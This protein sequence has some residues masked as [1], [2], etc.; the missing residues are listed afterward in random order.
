MA[1]NELHPPIDQELAES[2]WP[3]LQ[4]MGLAAG[5][6]LR[7]ESIAEFREMTLAG[8][9]STVSDGLLLG[10]R[11]EME[12]HAVPAPDGLPD[13]PALVIRPTGQSKP[14]ACLFVTANA[15][16]IIQSPRVFPPQMLEWAAELE[17]VI[18]S[19][20]PPVG[21]EHPH[22]ALVEGAYVG[23]LWAVEH[24]EELR[25]DPDRIMIGGTSGGGGLAAATALIARDRGGP[26]LTHQVLVCP[27]LDDREITVSSRYEGL[28]WDRIGNRTGWAVLLGDSAGG[29]DVSPY[30]APSRAEDLSGLPPAYLDTGGTEVFRDEIID[31]AARLGQ[32]GV[33]TELHVWAGAFH[34]FDSLG[35][36]EVGRAS[37]DARTSYIRRAIS[38]Q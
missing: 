20:A 34:G 2:I 13:M 28:N 30:A 38:Q 16:K 8:I 9:N 17:L 23:L 37:L 18:V 7:P 10:G 24:A 31:Y 5:F 36:S 26:Q 6:G 15:G 27:M 22:P 4:S 32:A 19:V 1:Q 11:L 3:Y 21:P 29:P 25:I 35:G 12:E 14:L 33:P